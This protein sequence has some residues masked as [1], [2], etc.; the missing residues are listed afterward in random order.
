M[1]AT[2][3]PPVIAV[4]PPTTKTA[5]GFGN[6]GFSG[7]SIW[8]SSWGQSKNK[9]EGMEQPTG[10]YAAAPTADM[11]LMPATAAEGFR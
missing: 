5:E 7:G 4:A 8:P 1:I 2:M 3:A 9:K 11:P 6:W 10:K